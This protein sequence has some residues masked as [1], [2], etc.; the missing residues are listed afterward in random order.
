[1]WIFLSAWAVES[2]LRSKISE[3]KEREGEVCFI[4]HILWYRARAGD[5][6]VFAV[7]FPAAVEHRLA[8]VQTVLS[9]GRSVYLRT[10]VI[11]RTFLQ[12]IHSP[13]V[14]FVMR[15]APSRK[16][17]YGP[18]SDGQKG[19]VNILRDGQYIKLSEGWVYGWT[20]KTGQKYK[21]HSFKGFK[22]RETFY[23]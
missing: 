3:G 11:R 21:N 1:M 4:I 15:V 20:G 6:I 13:S 22:T 18:R 19:T 5:C 9:S 8:V 12:T 17:C 16:N 7:K 2:V 10:P 23:K 14:V